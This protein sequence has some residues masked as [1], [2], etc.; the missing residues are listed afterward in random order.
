MDPVRSLFEPVRDKH[1]AFT[2]LLEKHIRQDRI[3]S[4]LQT[5]DYWRKLSLVALVLDVRI[6]EETDVG[7]CVEYA[8][9]KMDDEGRTENPKLTVLYTLEARS[10]THA[11]YMMCADACDQFHYKNRIDEISRVDP[12]YRTMNIEDLLLDVA[13]EANWEIDLLWDT[14][15]KFRTTTHPYHIV[16]A[17]KDHYF[18]KDFLRRN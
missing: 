16:P 2:T 14:F 3:Y 6:L 15:C 13:N 18:T 8:V 17:T 4:Q 10:I 5:H 9:V 1:G 7:S 12:E 11:F